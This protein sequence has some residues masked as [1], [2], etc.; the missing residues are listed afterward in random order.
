MWEVKAIQTVVAAMVTLKCGVLSQQV[1]YHFWFFV[2]ANDVSRTQG[3]KLG[4]CFQPILQHILSW[5]IYHLDA[6][7]IKTFI[8]L[9]MFQM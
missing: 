3:R 9:V 2:Q 6:V 5:M 1:C 7:V 8:K 4:N